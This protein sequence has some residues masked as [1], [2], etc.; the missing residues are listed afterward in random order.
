GCPMR[1]PYQRDR[2]RVIHATAFRRLTYKTQVFVFHEGDHYRTR[3]TH[4]LEVAQIARSIGRALGLDE[5]L[6][7]AVA[8]AHDVGH[9]PFGHAGEDALDAAMA[10]Y[11]GFDHNEQA[12]RIVTALEA[13]YAE[14]DGL[15][16]T[17]ETLEGLVKHNGPFGVEAPATIAAYPADLELGLYSSA[18]A[19]VAGLAD[20]IAYHCHD[21]DDGIRAGLLTVGE[22][23]EVP[24]A[25][26]AF[27][28]V[29]RR[30]PGLEVPRTVHEAVRRMID[31]MVGDVLA[32][33]RAKAQAR[34]PGSAAEVRRLGEPLVAFS[35]EIAEANA[36]LKAFLYARMYRHPGIIAMQDQAKAVVRD[37]FAWYLADPSLLPGSW[38]TAGDQ[39]AG[40]A[41]PRIVADYIAGMTDNFAHREH[42]RIA[43]GRAA[44]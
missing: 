3:L 35:T 13:R 21:I 36:A 39:T 25:G 16:L 33:T 20:D 18:E 5:D 2:D 17:W 40:K 15:N 10:P 29:A 43:Q 34:A 41:W 30:W 23:A 31:R 9:P 11:G 6:V 42:H 7:E 22:L 28:E 27:A 19:Q 14:F 32:T 8:L 44:A 4:S 12:F 1:T 24:L 26:A 38:R 37:L